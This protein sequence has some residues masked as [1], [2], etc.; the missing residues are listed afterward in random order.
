MNRLIYIYT[1][2]CPLSNQVRYVGKTIQNPKYRYSSHLSQ[3]KN[4]KKK[5]YTHCWI[6]SLLKKELKPILNIVEQ[7]QDIKRE[8]FWINH[9][10]KITHLTNF[11]NGGELGNLGKTWKIVNKQTYPRRMRKTLMIDQVKNEI[12]NFKSAKECSEFLNISESSVCR[13]I[14]LKKPYKKYIIFYSEEYNDDV[15]KNINIQNYNQPIVQLDILGNSIM[16]FQNAKHAS[17]YLNIDYSGIAKVLKG[18]LD[19]IK[20]FKFIYK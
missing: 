11:T 8:T 12:F 16:E 17:K 20:K 18:K 3:S 14:K 9:Y 4:N 5:D 19:T 6:K 7:T 2:S 15:L 10:R 1:L 13:Y